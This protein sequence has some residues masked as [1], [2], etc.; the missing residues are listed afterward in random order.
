MQ[1]SV[2]GH[3]LL[4]DKPA[5]LTSFDVIRILRRQLGIKKIGHAGTLDPFAT[6]LLLLGVGPGTKELTNLVGLSKV[7]DA[8]VRVGI[9]TDTGDPDGV[10]VDEKNVPEI[11]GSFIRSA[12]E[13]IVGVHT[14]RVPLYSAIKVEGKPLY[15]Y[16]QNGKIP[17]RIPEKTM[18]V[19]HTALVETHCTVGYCDISI[20][21]E[22]SSGTYIRTLAQLLGEF[23][24]YPAMLTSLRRLQ[25]GSYSVEDAQKLE[26]PEDFIPNKKSLEGK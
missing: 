11:A 6:G 18:E 24:G 20:R 15:W 13:K 17:P 21:V 1:A 2:S 8:V 22:V 10:V 9:A 3:I 7:Y 12:V 5:E 26:I 19:Y 14:L 16:A 25:I 23:L 4:V